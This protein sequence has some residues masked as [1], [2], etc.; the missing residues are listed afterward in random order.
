K[1][2]A[3]QTFQTSFSNKAF[4][5]NGKEIE[6][7]TNVGHGTMWIL[8][9]QKRND[10]KYPT[11]WYFATNL[12]VAK[13]LTNNTVSI[14]LTRL[15]ED[16]PIHAKLKIAPF[17]TEHFESYTIPLSNNNNNNN[18]NNPA[19]II[20][21]GNDFLKKDPKDY[22]AK[23]QK[24]K[25]KNAKEFVDFAVIEIDFEKIKLDSNF[26][27]KNL[28]KDKNGQISASQLSERVTANYANQKDKQIKFL[29][30][31]YLN[32]Y[33]QIN[34]PLLSKQLASYKGDSL[35]ALGYPIAI[36]DGFL[37]QYED[38]SQIKENKHNFSLWINSDANFYD[39]IKKIDEKY[40][41]EKSKWDKGD[42]LS[43][44]I[45]YRNFIDKPGILD[46]FIS[47]A[48]SGSNFFEY[49]GVQL[50]NFGLSYTPKHY[51][52]GGGA[53]G[54]S[55]RNQNNELVGIFHTG[56]PSTNTGVA[57]AFRSEGYDYK[58]I[59]GLYN[60]P[61]YDL[62]F[63]GGKDQQNSYRQAL[64]KIY[65]NLNNIKTALFSNG[66]NEIPIEYKFNK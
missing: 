1:D 25:F 58:G 20:F 45:G 14:R 9:Y 40:I 60:L 21:T 49:N 38:S 34:V 52:P 22:L 41:P 36:Y 46:E 42:Y 51:S 15:K 17:D 64:S 26:V 50:I 4:D 5:E 27:L 62:I 31:S 30:K 8:D 47:H 37:D 55:V 18:N 24:E 16:A 7:T 48:H 32:D 35:Y 44:Q 13:L 6:R 2:I 23:N 54:S 63:G 28:S 53:S 12:H 66:L 61:Q 59:Y 33:S 10:E 29:K 57:S 39:N 3:L 65:Q 56:N 43:Y 11:K 19:K